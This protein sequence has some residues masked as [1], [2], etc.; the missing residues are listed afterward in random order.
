VP[1]TVS[2]L[3]FGGR[4]GSRLFLCASHTLYAIYTNRRGAR[5]L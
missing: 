5:L 1:A 2:N 4:N 3:A